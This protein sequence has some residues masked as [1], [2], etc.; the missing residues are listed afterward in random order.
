MM[1]R[2]RGWGAGWFIKVLLLLLIR[3]KPA[4]GYELITELGKWGLAP[5]GRGQFGPIYRALRE[6]EAEGLITS[7]WDLPGGGPARRIY[8][9]TPAGEATLASW[10]NYLRQECEFIKEILKL[11]EE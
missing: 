7:Q 5:S 4:H 11:Y 2:G 1:R 9:I 6:L 10:V 8:T 3:K